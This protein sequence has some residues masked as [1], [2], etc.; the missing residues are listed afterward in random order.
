VKIPAG[1]NNDS[2]VRI[3][4]KGNPGQRGGPAGDLFIITRVLDSQ[5]FERKGD[6]LEC[7]VPITIVE[8]AL[9]TVLEVPT[10]EGGRA[11]I[12]IPPGTDSGKVLRLRGKGFPSLRGEGRGDLHVRVKVV[13]PKTM[14]EKA[15]KTLE[16]FAKQHPEDPRAHLRS[17]M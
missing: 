4:G 6:N 8:A 2:K 14:S 15:K 7:E 3:P 5:R 17:R 9:G 16:E 13:T 12:K 11:S 1:V 10:P